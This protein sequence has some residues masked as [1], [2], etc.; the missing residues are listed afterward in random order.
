[1]RCCSFRLSTAFLTYLFRVKYWQ[2]LLPAASVAPCRADFQKIEPGGSL[3]GASL[4]CS[5][6]RYRETHTHPGKDPSMFGRSLTCD[7]WKPKDKKSLVPCTREHSFSNSY[8][9]FFSISSPFVLTLLFIFW[10]FLMAGSKE[11]TCNGRPR[12]IL[13]RGKI[14]YF[15]S[16]KSH[17]QRALEEQN[18]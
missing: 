16:G 18:P 6:E 12:F 15:E 9:S 10:S 8:W 13:S 11:S 17:G 14:Q 5:R 4:S 3:G 7:N 1:M 2:N